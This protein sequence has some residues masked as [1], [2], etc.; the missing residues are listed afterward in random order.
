MAAMQMPVCDGFGATKGIRDFEASGGSGR[1][2]VVLVTASRL[3]DWVGDS[4]ETIGQR[5]LSLGADG[6]VVSFP[7]ACAPFWLSCQLRTL[8]S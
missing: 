4:S 5:A 3:T 6:A 7:A 8:S 2:P 1:V